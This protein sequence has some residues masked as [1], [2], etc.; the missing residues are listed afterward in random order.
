MEKPQAVGSLWNV[1][2]W[3][4]EMKNYSVPAKK[5]LEE[6]ILALIFEVSP[7]LKITHKKVKFQKAECEINIRKGK[8]ILVYDFELDIDVFG[9]FFNI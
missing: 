1:N 2:S 8:Q 9:I 6:K 3:H 7:T 5:I 4:W